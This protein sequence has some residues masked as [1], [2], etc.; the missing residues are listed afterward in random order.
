MTVRWTLVLVYL[1]VACVIFGQA[2]T[3]YVLDQVD[4]TATSIKENAIG[5]KTYKWAANGTSIYTVSDLL[6]KEGLAYIKN[7]G[8]GTLATSAMRGGNANHTLVMWN[9]LPIQSPTLGLLDMS[10]LAIDNIDEVTLQEGGNSSMW[11]SG[12]IAGVIGLNAVKPKISKIDIQSTIGSFGTYK[13][14]VGVQL[15]KRKWTYDARWLSLNAKNDFDISLPS[16]GIASRQSN[17]RQRMMHLTQS[18]SFIP[19][20]NHELSM[21]YWFQD[22][23]RQLPPTL[24]QTSSTADQL[25]RSQRLSLHYKTYGNSYIINARMAYFDERNDFRADSFSDYALNRFNIKMADLI[26][27]RS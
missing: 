4:I 13:N 7:Y 14:K 19:K 16:L 21:H 12:A 25:D 18:L 5:A 9:G 2:D 6:L 1:L 3:S 11:G 26:W 15:A 27:I 10:L 23:Y 22:A 17:A 24:T 20:A 8:P